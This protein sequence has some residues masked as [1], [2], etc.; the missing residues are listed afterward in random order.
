MEKRY[1]DQIDH[2]ASVAVQ[3]FL[4]CDLASFKSGLI[5]F[6]VL[7]YTFRHLIALI[8]QAFYDSALTVK[9]DAL[10]IKGRLLE[11]KERWENSEA[12]EALISNL[13]TIRTDIA[14]WRP[15]RL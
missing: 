10:E 1:I 12:H 2:A 6:I 5:I 11:Y 9:S 4:N 15:N 8:T 3:Y 7:A 14:S 13:S